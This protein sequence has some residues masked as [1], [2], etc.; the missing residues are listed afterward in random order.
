MSANTQSNEK[1]G[2]MPS[3]EKYWSELNDSEKMERMRSIIH[4]LQYSIERVEKENYRL[5]KHFYKHQHD[6]VTQIVLGA[7]DAYDN[8]D[9]S[10]T[11]RGRRIGDGNN[12]NEVYF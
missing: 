11:P 3:R 10:L 8:G 9:C 5:R 6:Q 12:P 4:S 2:G 1:L 7:L